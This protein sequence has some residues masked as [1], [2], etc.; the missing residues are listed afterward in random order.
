MRRFIIDAYDGIMNARYNPLRHIPNQN[1]RQVVM[2]AL[3]WMWCIV[4]SAW[5]GSYLFLGVNIFYH[6][7][8]LFGLFVTVGTFEVFTRP[9]YKRSH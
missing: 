6:S 8:L 3:A 9:D 5:T 7:L 4:F 2:V 1:T